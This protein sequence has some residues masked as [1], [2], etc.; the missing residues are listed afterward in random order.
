M[1]LDTRPVDEFRESHI[2]GSIF[3]GLDGNFAP[4]V[5]ALIKDLKQPIVFLTEKGREEEVVTRLSRVGYD[6]T[7][8]YLKGGIDAWIIAGGEIDKVESVT[9]DEV[10]AMKASGKDITIMDVRKKSEYDSEHVIDAENMPLDEINNRMAKVDDESTYH[11]HC[12]GGYRSMI[13]ISILKARGF[14]NL[15]DIKGGFK[16]LAEADIPKTEYVCPSTLL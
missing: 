15:I 10:A 13:T 1:I 8:G 6:N 11:V 14:H 9:A 7:L 5:G 12:A 16:A 2:P 3:I 4:W